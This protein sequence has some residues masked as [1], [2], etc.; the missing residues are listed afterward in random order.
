[1]RKFHSLFLA[2]LLILLVGTQTTM[3]ENY[4]KN[5]TEPFLR[6][7]RPRKHKKWEQSLLRQRISYTYVINQATN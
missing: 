2:Q 7:T 5:N 1:M 3:K 6:K 4:V